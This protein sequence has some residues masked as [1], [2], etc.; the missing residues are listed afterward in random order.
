MCH[1]G[2]AVPWDWSYLV[3]YLHFVITGVTIVVVAVPVGLA[4]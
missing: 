4:L 1:Y 2:V 3:D